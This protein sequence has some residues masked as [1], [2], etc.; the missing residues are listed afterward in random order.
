M[1][2]LFALLLLAVF[3]AACGDATDDTYDVVIRGGTILD[4]TGAAPFEGDIAIRDDRI[5]A[6]GSLGDSPAKHVIDASGLFVTPGFIDV[7]SH[8]GEAL[9]EE[10]LS[11]AHALLAQGLTTVAINPDGGGPIDIAAQRGQLLEHGLG[12]NVI[13]LV[14]HGSIR[15]QVLGSSDRDPTAEELDEMKALVRA[16]M[17]EGAFGMSSGLFYTP[18][19]WSKTGEVIAMAREIAPYDGVYSSHIRDEADYGIG[20]VASVDEVIRIA[21]EAGVTGIVTHIKALGPNVWGASEEIVA[22]IEAARADGVRIWADQYPYHASATGFVPALVPAWAREGDRLL[23]RLDDP[24]TADRIRTGMAGSLARRGGAER[25]M[26]RGSGEHAGRTLAEVAAARG[27][28]PIAAAEQ[29]IRNDE[30]SGIISFNMHED[31]I[32]RFMRQPWMMTSSDGALTALGDGVP[33]P[34]NYGAFPRKIRHYVLEEHVVDLPTAI[35]SMTSLPA[36]VFGVEDRGILR[37]GAIADIVVFDIDRIRDVATFID[38]HHHS[39]GM[40]HILVNGTPVLVDGEY[41]GD[42]AGQVLRRGG[43]GHRRSTETMRHSEGP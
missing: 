37:E 40:V 2:R 31:D 7:H 17:E 41:T 12:V 33:H 32:A 18:A 5:V 3:V 20:V 8:A 42:L 19:N 43:P 6:L 16:G 30:V 29:L 22:N 27:Q 26:F 21:W 9:A 14:P 1:R 35:R 4:G 11:R 23:E 38:P 36:E 39:E 24:A 15:S 28:E 13:Q 34:R 25:I 10:E